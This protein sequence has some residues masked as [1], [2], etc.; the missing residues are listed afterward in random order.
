[1]WVWSQAPKFATVLASNSW[2]SWVE[3][4]WGW[5]FFMSC[6]LYDMR[7][8]QCCLR[9]AGLRECLPCDDM[10]A[11]H[12]SHAIQH[13]ILSWDFSN[14]LKEKSAPWSHPPLP[15][16]TRW[17]PRWPSPSTCGSPAPCVTPPAWRTGRPTPRSPSDS[18]PAGREGSPAPSSPLRL[19][20]GVFQLLPTSFNVCQLLF[21]RLAAA[22]AARWRWDCVC[23]LLGF[24]PGFRLRPV[25]FT[26]PFTSPCSFGLRWKSVFKLYTNWNSICTQKHPPSFTPGFKTGLLRRPIHTPTSLKYN[27]H[28]PLWV[29]PS[30]EKK[31]DK[32]WPLSRVGFLYLSSPLP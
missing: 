17:S 20:F 18:A 25:C 1:M 5:T 2:F 31:L 6:V 29:I 8:L 21:Q 16:S 15:P 12:S 9:S 26:G 14:G 23:T 28:H 13:F 3:H 7:Q 4:S 10:P 32:N 30:E 24:P 22:A 11:T 19:I 27:W